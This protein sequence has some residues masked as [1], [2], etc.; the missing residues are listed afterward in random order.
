MPWKGILESLL[1][2]L[3]LLPENCDICEFGLSG[4]FSHLD[5]PSCHRPQALEL[6]QPR[7]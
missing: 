5:A 1:N 2:S 3:F 6:E 7:L 4:T